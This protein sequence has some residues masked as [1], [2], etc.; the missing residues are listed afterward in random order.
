LRRHALEALAVMAG[1]LLITLVI[2]AAVVR[3]PAER[4]FGAEIVGRHHD[5]FTVMQQFVSPAPLGLY[6][7]PVTDLTGAALARWIGAVA[8]YNWLVLV[9][10]PLSAAAAYLLA[11]HVGLTQ[12]AA[13]IAALLFAFSPFHLAQA[14]YHPH[15]AQTQWLALYLLA[16]WRC[17]DDA[18]GPA[19]AF[20]A[21]ATA[22]V[23][24]SNFYGGLIAAVITPFA[25]ATY[26]WACARTVPRAARHLAVTIAAVASIGVTGLALIAWRAP[27]VIS[28]PAAVAFTRTDLFT[29]SARW[30][31]YFVPPVAHPALGSLARRIWRATGVT[32]GLLEQQVSL[33]WSVAAL[34]LIAIHGWLHGTLRRQ[35]RNAHTP[36]PAESVVPV[37]AA[38]AIVALVC[39]LSPERVIFGVRVVRPAAMLY[40]IVPMFR[41]Y[42]RFGVIV[43][44]M[45]ALLAGIGLARLLA[46]GTRASH[47]AG[48]ALVLLACAEY[49]VSP[50]AM[51]RDVLPTEAHRWVMRQP[52]GSHVFDCSPVTPATASVAWLTTGRIRSSSVDTD[53]GEP[54]IAGRLRADGFTHLLVP[55]SW[56]RSWLRQ[57]PRLAGVRPTVQFDGADVLALDPDA[58]V[59][60]RDMTGFSAR[61]HD[62]R[63]SWR[64]MGDDASWTIVTPAPLTHV[65]LRV[66]LSAFHIVRPMRVQLDDGDA[67]QLDVDPEGRTYIVGP[68]AL[69]AGSHRLT[70]HSVVPA[71]RANA[72][73]GNGD[74]RT[75]SIAIG[76]W[77]W[78]T[79]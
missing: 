2:A 50:A 4:I 38:I 25:I 8:A 57:H 21:V 5:P 74:P 24:L 11:R 39:S 1:A 20:L 23:A 41:S 12:S 78:S 13:A 45:T 28:E 9:T 22:A 76:A 60:T 72:I 66:D 19:V 71:T 27:A 62:D 58:P 63:T 65:S 36:T 3:A 54:Q 42:A 59:Y 52:P 37:L 53:C 56:Q 34:A 14:A 46:R 35:P 49:T 17:I 77:E 61:E 44:L 6:L 30:W 40:R 48:V 75:L 47:A 73:I 29:F 70:F 10:F 15:V 64:W 79:P 18:T 16:L 67:Q 51:S 43:Q 33:G 55:D 68:F 32:D 69:S 26:W 7:Q 31:G